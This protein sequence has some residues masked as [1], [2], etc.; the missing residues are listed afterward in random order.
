MDE[1]TGFASPLGQRTARE[2]LAYI[3][4]TLDAAGR[5]SIVPGA[6]FVVIGLLALF[7]A[8]LNER[9][10]YGAP[11]SDAYLRE[12]ASNSSPMTGV[13]FLQAALLW[14]G[15]LIASLA[16]GV[17]TMWRKARRT[18]QVFWSPLL[19]KALWGYVAAMALG[20]VLTIS[21][22]GHPENLPEIWLGCYGVALV[23]A[24]AVSISPIRW[25]GICFL[26]LAAIA[27]ITDWPGSLLLAAGFGGLHIVFGGYIAWR[28]EG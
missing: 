20:G 24:G 13:P 23:G 11:W 8:W 27:A 1:P 22:A 4:R 17:F 5:L 7:T 6:G 14:G 16:V 15:L 19:H 3:R 25:M 2:E 26:A 21:V 9:H 10:N 18:G 12:L 28:H